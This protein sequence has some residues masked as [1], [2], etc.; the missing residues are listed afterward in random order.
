M[1][2]RVQAWGDGRD[3]AGDDRGGA[4]APRRPDGLHPPERTQ[5]PEKKCGTRRLSSRSRTRG[6]LSSDQVVAKA[7]AFLAFLSGVPSAP[8]DVAQG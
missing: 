2:G 3:R 6:G 7:Q 8:S 4:A 5:R 1:T